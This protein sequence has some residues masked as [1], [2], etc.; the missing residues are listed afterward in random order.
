[1]KNKPTKMYGSQR[2]DSEEPLLYQEV[3]EYFLC[4]EWVSLIGIT[5]LANR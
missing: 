2:K 1:M 5:R 4:M 3:I